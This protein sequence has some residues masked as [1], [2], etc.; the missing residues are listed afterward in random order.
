MFRQISG[1]ILCTAATATSATT[2]IGLELGA[3]SA[4]FG[5]VL[6]VVVAAALVVGFQWMGE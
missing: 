4:G 3:I 5:V 2:V 6:A 1:A